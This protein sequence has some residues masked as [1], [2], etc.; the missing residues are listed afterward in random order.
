MALHEVLADCAKLVRGHG[1]FMSDL[2]RQYEKASDP[3]AVVLERAFRFAAE[4]LE[5]MSLLLKR[6]QFGLQAAMI[7]RGFYEISTR[8]LWATREKHGW[9]RLQIHWAKEDARFLKP[10]KDVP[11][12]QEAV[13]TELAELD[14]VVKQEDEDGKPLS[15]APGMWETIQA[16]DEMDRR[17]EVHV[18]SSDFPLKEYV[19]A[20][21]SLCR[22]VHAHP[23]WLD[24]MRCE[25]AFDRQVVQ[26][27]V[28]AARNLLRAFCHCLPVEHMKEQLDL[29]EAEVVK[30]W[31]G[32]SPL[33]E[34]PE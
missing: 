8:L 19:I 29:V 21:T 11:R 5:A 30:L 20:W 28:L 14:G 7:C 15:N 4:S 34:R 17:D 27:A 13:A 22:A 16:I 23:S 18:V 12:F 6:G 26:A 9:R 25:E 1:H 10:I 2:G 31:S 3:P 32:V 24:R 33:S